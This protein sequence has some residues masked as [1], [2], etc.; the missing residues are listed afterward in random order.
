MQKVYSMLFLFY[1]ILSI[2]ILMMTDYNN[3][4]ISNPDLLQIIVFYL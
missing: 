2:V 3:Y 1:F 4:H